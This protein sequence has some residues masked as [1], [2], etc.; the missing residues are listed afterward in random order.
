MTSA[1]DVY[2]H[3]DL[4]TKVTVHDM[5]P[6]GDTRENILTLHDYVD[7]KTTLGS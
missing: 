7:G 2:Y 3:G 5:A 4:S 1:G 6:Q